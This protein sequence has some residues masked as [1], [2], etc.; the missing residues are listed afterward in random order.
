MCTDA[1]NPSERS[2]GNALCTRTRRLRG[3]GNRAKV[4]V[5]AG[6]TQGP[7]PPRSWLKGQPPAASVCTRETSGK[8]EGG[9]LLL[10][11]NG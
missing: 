1:C 5:Q 9:A 6:P 2:C 7:E 4:R 3:L 8:Q 10:R 11:G